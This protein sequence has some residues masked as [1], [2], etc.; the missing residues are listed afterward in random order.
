M[1]EKQ[2]GDMKNAHGDEQY[3]VGDVMAAKTKI[4]KVSSGELYKDN[5]TNSVNIFLVCKYMLIFKF[6]SE[7]YIREDKSTQ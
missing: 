6:L 7:K 4:K 3:M 5:E 2:M 1:I